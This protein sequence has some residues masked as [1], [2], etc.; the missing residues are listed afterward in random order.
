V[1]PELDRRG[2]R[3][4]RYRGG[5]R[6]AATAAHTVRVRLA[7]DGA[8]IAL[9]AVLC[10]AVLAAVWYLNRYFL[11]EGLVAQ[12]ASRPEPT[13]P[14]PGIPV[15]IAI[16]TTI[17]M[18]FIATR[19]RFGRYVYGIGG[20]PEAA[21]LAGIKTKRTHRQDVRVDGFPW[22]GLPPPCASRA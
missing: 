16:G 14:R 9:G 2:A 21:V 22:S 13:S 3:L 10:G 15:L 1:E 8:E 7:T 18:T 4:Y 17:V 5:A 11:P 6:D 12:R 19:R 20:N